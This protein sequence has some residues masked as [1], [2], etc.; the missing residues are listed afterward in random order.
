MFFELGQFLSCLKQ[1]LYRF[2]NI[3]ISSNGNR[4]RETPK[5]IPNLEAK[6]AHDICVLPS[7][8]K[9]CCCLAFLLLIPKNPP[10]FMQENEKGIPAWLVCEDI[11]NKIR[12]E[13]IT[14]A[15]DTLQEAIDSKAIEIKGSL[16]NL[17][18]R[19]GDTEMKMFI[20][21][22]LIGEKESIM[23]RYKRY[24]SDDNQST[25]EQ[26][27]QKERLKKFLLSVEQISLLMNY[28]DIF[29]SWMHDIAMQVG[30]K[31]PS[32]VIR[33]TINGDE[34]RLSVLNYTLNNSKL[35]K[36]K[37]LDK[38]GTRHT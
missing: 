31:D 14:Q 36:E 27:Q 35:E 19:P 6:P 26:I 29:N 38:G 1:N 37:V 18:D 24:A 23:E 13:L 12:T 4:S 2:L 8:G 3:I 11:F 21:K 17:P 20:I 34:S 33:K 15:M 16:V 10:D 9:V 5:P 32:D 28:G 25:P 30:V 7:G 22:K